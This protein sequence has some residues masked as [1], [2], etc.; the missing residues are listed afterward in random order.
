MTI[1]HEEIEKWTKQ[2]DYDLGTAQKNLEF[3]AYS[4]CAFLCEQAVEKYLKALHM[5]WTRT[6]PPKTHAIDALA[7]ALDVPSP[8]REH[9]FN[10]KEDYTLTRY[11]DVTIRPPFEEYDEETAREKLEAAKEAIAWIRQ[12]LEERQEAQD[13]DSTQ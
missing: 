8:F 3:E 11:P 13:E 5:H 2:A 7:I 12:Q 6:L 10:L 1:N 4:T 9:I